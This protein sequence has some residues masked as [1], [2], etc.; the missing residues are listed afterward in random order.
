MESGCIDWVRHSV[1]ITPIFSVIQH[2]HY[3]DNQASLCCRAIL[4]LLRIKY[5]FESNH[6]KSTITSSGQPSSIARIRH[7]YIHPTHPCSTSWHNARDVGDLSRS[8]RHPRCVRAGPAIRQLQAPCGLQ[9][10]RLPSTCAI[11]SP[12]SPNMFFENH[13]WYSS[14]PLSAGIDP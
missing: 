9:L 6:F 11:F 8:A 2:H 10:T 12:S 7:P 1:G 13:S 4:S 3:V 5:K 14:S